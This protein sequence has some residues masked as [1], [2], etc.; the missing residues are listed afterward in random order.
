MVIVAVDIQSTN[1]ARAASAAYYVANTASAVSANAAS[2]ASDVN[3]IYN[4]KYTYKT[5]MRSCRKNKFKNHWK[6]SD[7][8]LL[9]KEIW[10][11][12][13]LTNLPILADS[14][15]ES[16]VPNKMVKHMREEE[17][18]SLADW[19]LWNLNLNLTS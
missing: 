10:N 7:N 1:P 17:N 9:A 11:N 4:W 18:N 3:V 8:I 15:E 14:L 5:F 13:N 12:R 19:F 6:T 16:G 2:A